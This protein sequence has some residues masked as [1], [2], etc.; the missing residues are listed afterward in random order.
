MKWNH[1]QYWCTIFKTEEK[2]TTKRQNWF[3]KIVKSLVKNLFWK[4]CAIFYNARWNVI[5][6]PWRKVRHVLSSIIVL[7][8]YRQSM[9]SNEVFFAHCA[10]FYFSCNEQRCRNLVHKSVKTIRTIGPKSEI[11]LNNSFFSLLIFA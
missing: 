10:E 8:F 2:E 4:V 11:G 1:L 7:S 5:H 9:I 6:F 3:S